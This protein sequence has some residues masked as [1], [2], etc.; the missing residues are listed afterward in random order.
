[1]TGSSDNNRSERQG[2]SRE[3]TQLKEVSSKGTTVGTRTDSEAAMWAISVRGNA[4]SESHRKTHRVESGGTGRKFMHLT[5]GDLSCESSAG[6]SRGRSSEEACRKA[7][8][9]KGRRTKK[10]RTTDGPYANGRGVVR[11]N[12][13]VA[14]AA[15]TCAGR[16]EADWWNPVRQPRMDSEPEVTRKEVVENA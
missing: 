15:A 16:W 8:R 2:G 1:M 11:N 3:G 6:V 9:T 14:T 13:G 5:R 4:K 10:G 7:G 12:M